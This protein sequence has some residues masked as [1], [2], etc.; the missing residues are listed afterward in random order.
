MTDTSL[1]EDIQSLVAGYV[2]GDLDSEER[3]QFQHLLALHP[4]LAQEIATLKETLSVLPYGLPPQRPAPEV[5]SRLLMNV[6]KQGMLQE[7]DA[8]LPP[9]ELPLADPSPELAPVPQ[10]QRSLSPSAVSSLKM[11]LVAA[12]AVVLGGA[13]VVLAHRAATLQTRLA[14]ANQVVELAMVGQADPSESSSES[15]ALTIYPA[16]ALLIEQWS[17][18][19]QIMQDH[20]GSLTRSQGPVDIA[21]TDPL[22]L[23]EKFR[24]QRVSSA[25][26]ATQVPTLSLSQAQLLGGSPCQFSQTKGVRMTYSL[27]SHDPISLYQIEMHGRRV[28]HFLRYVHYRN[29]RQHQYGALATR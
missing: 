23:R 22:V 6:Q 17:G 2:L 26:L 7:G 21:A 28:S 11:R 19:T 18:L 3:Q 5:R 4:E 9:A 15:S 20:V 8:N 29:P 16:D 27:P 24:S 25:G 14:M 13:S 12:I 1:P 10:R